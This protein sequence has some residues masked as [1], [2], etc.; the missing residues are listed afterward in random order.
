MSPEQAS[1]GT[2]VVSPACDIYS[3]GT[4]LYCLLTGKAPYRARTQSNCSTG[5]RQ[6]IFP[7]GRSPR[8]LRPAGIDLPESDGVRPQD[9]YDSPRAFAED[10]EHWLADEPISVHREKRIERTAQWLRRRRT[11]AQAAAAA[12]VIISLVSSTAAVL[13]DRAWSYERTAR[14]QERLALV[15]AK[16][17]F[18]MARD[19]V[20]RVLSTF[21]EGRLASI[22]EAEGIRRQIAVDAAEFNE[23]FLRMRPRDPS[24]RSEAARVYREAGNINRML[25]HFSDAVG[26]YTR[27]VN[28]LEQVIKDY[29]DKVVYRIQ[30]AESLQDASVG[31]R[32]E[33]RPQ[34][35]EP[36]CRRALELADRTLDKS[37]INASLRA[38]RADCL[39]TLAAIFLETGRFAEAQKAGEEA[40][41]LRRPMA[42][43]GT[44]R[45]LD[46]IVF[47]VALKDWGESLY[48]GGK[49]KEAEP[50]ID[51]AIRRLRALKDGQLDPNRLAS[52]QERA[53]RDN[54]A[55][56]LADRPDRA[57]NDPLKRHSPSF[58]GRPGFQGIDRRTDRTW[59]Q[60]IDAPRRRMAF[61]L[62]ISAAHRC[63]RH[64][65]TLPERKAI[66]S[67]HEGRSKR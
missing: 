3:L 14:K 42:E 5:C 8:H 59:R 20:N 34:I 32:M 10:I 49:S 27:C 13:V 18:S 35:A 38:T 51:E 39:Q 24:V 41:S 7:S 12:L 63:E 52:L 43:S 23:R 54:A 16:S 56:I 47:A 25:G 17:S 55:F 48:E 1:G 37:P 62:R 44:A 29:P 60:Q 66:W 57:G 11:W 6:A 22:P 30:L 53:I 67:K 4:T 33:G 46:E 40:V 26:A 21:A 50:V 61:A 36:F 65:A 9:R 28:L 45:Y 2:N 19:A 31:L 64:T 58:G 15:E